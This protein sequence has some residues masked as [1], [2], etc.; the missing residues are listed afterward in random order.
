M[1]RQ[2]KKKKERVQNRQ[3]LGTQV[4]SFVLKSRTSHWEQMQRDTGIIILEEVYKKT[5]FQGRKSSLLGHILL[6][7]YKLRKNQIDS[8]N[9]AATKP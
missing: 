4:I 1:T 2:D 5:K 9:I 6:I 8:S 7:A 3:N